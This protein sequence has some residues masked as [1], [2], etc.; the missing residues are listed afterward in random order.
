MKE[1]SY[2]EKDKRAYADLISQKNIGR[3]GAL[4]FRHLLLHDD[5]KDL[6]S[7]FRDVFDIPKNGLAEVGTS[8]I[9]IS[10]DK[11]NKIFKEHV[12]VDYLN[13][14][15]QTK[16]AKLVFPIE[17]E[18]ALKSY[19][20]KINLY[21]FL[22]EFSENFILTFIYEYILFNRFDAGFYLKHFGDDHIDYDNQ[23]VN[24]RLPLSATKHEISEYINLI[25]ENNGIEGGRH[26]VNGDMAVKRD[27]IR[28][29]K[30]LFENIEIFNSWQNITTTEKYEYKELI[31]KRDIEGLSS[32]A[33]EKRYRT[34]NRDKRNINNSNE[35]INGYQNDTDK[36]GHDPDDIHDFES[37]FIN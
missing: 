18:D 21:Y 33:I 10:K 4:L 9:G 6:V 27:R 1:I 2:S 29:P 19:I 25:Y 7:D 11:R 15:F 23:E 17:Y 24:F 34:I 37:E 5:F 31:I 35:Y 13:I 36:V 16:K 28:L 32:E 26:L 3:R 12:V 22:P 8:E 20:D 14:M 30:N